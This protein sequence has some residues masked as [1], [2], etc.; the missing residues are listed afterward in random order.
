LAEPDGAALI[1]AGARLTAGETWDSVARIALR[2]REQ[3]VGP[4]SVV[5]VALPPL[6]QPVLALALWGLGA[7]GAVAPVAGP[8]RGRVLDILVTSAS[9]PDLPLERQLVVDDGWLT[10]TAA[11]DPEAFEPVPRPGDELV[12]LVFSS[13]TTGAPKAI[14]FTSDEIRERVVRSRENWLLRHPALTTLGLGTVSGSAT[15]FAAMDDGI[16]YLVAGSADENLRLLTDTGARAVHGSPVQLS[17]LLTA[18]RR[19]GARP[20]AL[21]VVQSAGSPLPDLLAARLEREL[22]VEVEIVYGATEVDAVAIRRGPATRPGDVGPVLPYATVEVLGEDGRPV[23]DGV[24]G[25]VRIRRPLQAHSSFRGTADDDAAFQDGWFVPGDLGRLVAGRLILGARRSELINAAGLKVDPERVEQAAREQPG[26]RFSDV[27]YEYGGNG[28][29]VVYVDSV[30]TASPVAIE[31]GAGGA[32]VTDEDASPGD[33]GDT[34]VASTTAAGGAGAAGDSGSCPEPD[35]A[36]WRPGDGARLPADPSSCAGGAGYALDELSG[37]DGVLWPVAADPAAEFGTG[38][39][40]ALTGDLAVSPVAGTGGSVS[41]ENAV[42]GSDGLVILRFAPPAPPAPPKP[43]LA[44]TGVDMDAAVPG[45]A[46][47][48]LAGGAVLLGL[49][50]RRRRR[51]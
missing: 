34:I 8:E 31:V 23:P 29:A 40:V 4:G 6:L 14:P 38:G 15:F 37:R 27:S 45:L 9:A 26:V 28:G 17:E 11:L 5:G 10:G 41:D 3:G 47:L 24:E 50:R 48:A 12:R 2:L 42:A 16:A 18:V 49:A 51:A 35:G 1:A 30:S 7:I 13:G 22:G 39:S 44:A 36:A 46:A 32:G 25:V 21:E 20:S 19:R 43:T 33:G